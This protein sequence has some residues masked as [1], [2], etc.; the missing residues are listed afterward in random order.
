MFDNIKRMLFRLV[1]SDLKNSIKE[2]PQ[3]AIQKIDVYL[4]GLDELEQSKPPPGQM[5]EPE[6]RG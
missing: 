6:S 4:R 3:K 1:L 2:D 5:P